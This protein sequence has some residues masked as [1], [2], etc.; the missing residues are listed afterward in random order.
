MRR[1]ALLY[2][3]VVEP[4]ADD[5]SGFPGGAAARYKLPAEEFARHLDALAA[6]T[7]GPPARVD[8]A[9]PPGAAVPWLLTFDDGGASA[10]AVGER[11]A[12][13]G[14]PAHFFVTADRVGTRAFLGRDDV[15]ALAALGHLIGSHSCSHPSDMARSP[16]AAVLA[17]WARSAAVLG[18]LVGEP[19]R[20]ASVPAGSYA[21][22]VAEA[23]SEAGLT[24]LFNSEPVTRARTVEGCL[25]LGRYTLRRGNSA[26]TAARLAAGAPGARA[27][28]L[29]AWRAKRAVRRVMGGG[30][31]RMRHRLL[32]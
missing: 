18:D 28:Q 2:H 24:V 20:V 3:D 17:E 26:R 23:A 16:R 7:P 30:Y 4:G 13:R 11:L 22:H 12:E 19:V 5:G 21:R 15:R 10:R 25:V 14:W 29:A 27:G 9:P 8:A 1:C 31:E 32:D 6:A